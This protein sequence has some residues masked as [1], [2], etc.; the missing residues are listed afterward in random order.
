MNYQIELLTDYEQE[1]LDQ[2]V[3]LETEAFGVGA[4]NKWHLVPFINH[5]RVFVLY[6]QKEP[7]GLLELLRDFSSPE[8]AYI[9]GFSIKSEYKGQGLGT[10]LL[11]YTLNW[12][13]QQDFKRVELTVAPDN[14]VAYHLYKDKFGFAEEEY[15]SAEYGRNEP[16]LVMSLEL[17]TDG[18]SEK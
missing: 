4:L 8:L 6:N 15:R 11:D 14:K 7:I 3:A 10:K 1:L 5:G 13:V 9:F 12:L 18:W 17:S 2:L 16:R